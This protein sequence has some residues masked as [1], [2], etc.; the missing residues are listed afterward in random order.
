MEE[1]IPA[2]ANRALSANSEIGATLWTA[3]VSAFPITPDAAFVVAVAP[4]AAHSKHHRM[5]SMQ[6]THTG[7][8]HVRSEAANG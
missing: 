6:L 2:L 7:V 8:M 3:A 4:I 5:Q 1:M